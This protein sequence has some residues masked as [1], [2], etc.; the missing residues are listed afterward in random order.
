MWQTQIYGETTENKLI[1]GGCIEVIVIAT[2]IFL[3][4]ISTQNTSRNENS[5]RK[6]SSLRG[7]TPAS[8]RPNTRLGISVRF[9]QINYKINIHWSTNNEIESINQSINHSINHSNNQSINQSIHQS[10][11]GL[12][13]YN[14]FS[15]SFKAYEF[16]RLTILRATSA[17][18]WH[19]M[20]LCPMQVIERESVTDS[21]KSWSVTLRRHVNSACEWDL[22]PT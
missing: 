17:I 21:A 5:K 6:G 10:I 12:R 13:V 4:H 20:T 22:W 19:K 15:A 9:S 3:R 8:G 11:N 18:R 16:G 2:T 14:R 1:Y 7:K